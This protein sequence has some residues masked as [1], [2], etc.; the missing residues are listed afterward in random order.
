L[1]GPQHDRPISLVIAQQYSSASFFSLHFL[2]RM[3]KS[4]TLFL[5]KIF[6]SFITSLKLRV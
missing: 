5:N 6:I 2:T 3:E 4:S 1:I